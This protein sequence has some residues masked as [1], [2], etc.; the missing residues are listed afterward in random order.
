MAANHRTED[1]LITRRK[2]VEFM[3]A[4]VGET[5]IRVREIPRVMIYNKLKFKSCISYVSERTS[6]IQSLLAYILPN[7]VREK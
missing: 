3:T 1:V 7:K 4:I 6:N 2:K 5:E